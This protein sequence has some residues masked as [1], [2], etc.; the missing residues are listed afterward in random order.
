M[1]LPKLAV[2]TGLM[3][4]TALAAATAC[5]ADAAVD[6]A[7]QTLFADGAIESHLRDRR[8][9]SLMSGTY[10]VRPGDTL[11]GIIELAFPGTGLRKSVLRQAFIERNGQAF[12]NNNPNGLLA[13]ATLVVPE[14][15][16]IHS[17]LFEDYASIRA[18]YAADTSGW[19][20]FP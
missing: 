16:D 10:E 1:H 15:L 2:A 8:Q 3:V 6:A 5:A 18:R 14:A 17:L 9:E 7:L 11:D 4:V 20:R 13:G 12:R 19:V